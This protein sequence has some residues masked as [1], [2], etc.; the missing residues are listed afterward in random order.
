M[1]GK[2]TSINLTGSPKLAYLLIGMTAFS[3]RLYFNFSQELIPGVNGG[4]YPLQVRS[5]L[6]NGSLGFPDM[7]FLFYLDAWLLKL[8]SFIGF[9]SSDVLILQV[10]KII[11]SLSLPLVLIPL[12]KM[13]STE[14]SKGTKLVALSLA[15]FAVLSFS[16]LILTSD[17]QKNAL[18]ITFS[19]FSIAY[20]MEYVKNKN[21]APLI[22]AIVWLLLTGLTHFGTFAFLLIFLSFSLGFQYRSR[23]ILPLLLMAGGGLALI[24]LSDMARLNRLLSVASLLF[25]RPALL[26]GGLAPPEILLITFSIL[27]SI[28]GFSL[29]RN[30]DNRLSAPQKGILFSASLGLIACSFPL[31]DAEYFKRASLFLFVLQLLAIIQIVS[32]RVHYRKAISLVLILLTAISL[33]AVVGHPKKSVLCQDAFVDLKKIKAVI[34][35]EPGTIVIA[36]HGLEWWTAWTLRTR[37]GQDKSMDGDFFKKYNHIL[38]LNQLSGFGNEEERRAFHE[39]AIP[40]N[41]T[42]LYSSAYFKVYSMNPLSLPLSIP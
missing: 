8:L 18:A 23:A 3:V 35:H 37:V 41:S 15:F 32:Q 13:I 34:T 5:I 4:Y 30:K 10:V 28:A 19:C 20:F 29:L 22:T 7:P 42:L 36:R 25:E 9:A 24:G 11:D 16:P 40:E 31:L 27:L 33:F 38:G 26:H 17:L 14:E 1:K 6:E 12:Y 2:G 39:P 21:L